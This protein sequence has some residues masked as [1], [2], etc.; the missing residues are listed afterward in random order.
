MKRHA[1]GRVLVGTAVLLFAA[2]GGG[3]GGG[4]DAG[5]T[6]GPPGNALKAT[7][8]VVV[9]GSGDGTVTVKADK[10]GYDPAFNV[11]SCAKSGGTCTTTVD[12]DAHGAT[13][14]TLTATPASSSGFYRWSDGCSCPSV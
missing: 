13:M 2:C 9:L 11:V 7:L 12:L 6:G 8:T 1:L 14:L 4:N 5:T 10:S 3:A